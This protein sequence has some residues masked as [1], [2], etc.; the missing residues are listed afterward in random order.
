MRIFSDHPESLRHVAVVEQPGRRLRRVTLRAYT[1]YAPVGATVCWHHVHASTG[2]EAKRLAM[3]EHR[4][5][6][7]GGR[8]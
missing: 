1:Q 6:C 7:M 8:K 4:S 5:K 2:A 3:A